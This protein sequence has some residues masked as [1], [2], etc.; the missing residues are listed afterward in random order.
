M[1][2][3]RSP[4]VATPL[5]IA[6]W[7]AGLTPG[8][9]LTKFQA[10]LTAYLGQPVSLLASSGRASL[11]LLL[12]SLRQL[13]PGRTT[14][15]LPAYTCPALVKVILDVGL[16]PELLE[17]ATTGFGVTPGR[18][19]A[20]LSQRTLALIWVHPFGLPQPIPAIQQAVKAA[21]ALF[22][23]DTAQAIGA[24]V[25]SRPVGTL[26]DFGLFSL[27]P[28]KAL[29]L[30]GGG[31]VTVNNQFYQEAIHQQ[32]KRLRPASNGVA[33]GRLL[34]LRLVFH[35][36]G[37]RFATGLGLH[38]LGEQENSWGYR[39]TKLSEAQAAIGCRLLPRLDDFN[40]QRRENGR[41]ILAMSGRE[42]PPDEGAIYL[43]LPLRTPRREELYQRLWTA[44]IGAGRLY[45]RPLTQIFPH[46]TSQPYPQAQT[47]ADQLLTL[48]THHYLTPTDIEKIATLIK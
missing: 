35:P 15:L 18:V 30:G 41:M 22:I 23:E 38:R 45:G 31:F 11:Y 1:S 37:W 46:L 10:G 2:L 5:P 25:E 6:D 44:G 29:S 20:Q 40:Q 48:P 9:A 33:L 13:H 26:G 12:D 36:A 19:E 3:H 28:G 4:P 27:G 7:L 47:L 14:V 34:A 8:R 39:L 43:R 21:G 24:K 17:M 42:L 16:T 32:E